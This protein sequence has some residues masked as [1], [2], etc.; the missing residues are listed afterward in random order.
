LNIDPQ[1]IVGKRTIS[2]IHRDTRFSNDKAPYK[3]R[4]WITFKGPRKDWAD[5][6][7][8]FFEINKDSY[9]YGMGFYAASP[10][11]MRKFRQ[12]I[13]EKPQA[14]QTAVSF[15]SK[16][17]IFVL[18]GEKYKKTFDT[19]KPSDI[20]EWYQRKNFYLICTKKDHQRLFSKALVD[21][22]LSGYNMIAPLYHYLLKLKHRELTT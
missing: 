8:Y 10:E 13:D 9:R 16:Q 22:L 11:T 21:D 6:P 15:Y 1:F 14:F 17:N 7:A 4:M 2:R 5:S 3:S 20:Q 19:S 18:E 12:A